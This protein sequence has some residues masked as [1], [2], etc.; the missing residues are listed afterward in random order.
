VNQLRE[1]LT[2][3]LIGL[4][5]QDASDEWQWFEP[6]VS[7]DNAKLPHA[8]ILSGRWAG[9]PRALEIGLLTLRWL[10]DKQRSASGHFRPIGCNGFY[11][12]GG[13]P[14]EFDQ[15]P[16]EAQSMVSACI[17]AYR[18]TNDAFW[19]NQAHVAFEWFLGR[20]VLGLWLYDP[21]S[22]GCRDGLHSDRVNQNQ[23][24]ESTLAFLLALTEMQLLE[25]S[26]ATFRQATEAG[27]REVEPHEQP[28][29]AR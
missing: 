1:T 21:H 8:L 29:H 26:L 17:E 22:G 6:T 14:A 10:A 9:N 18:V 7:Y 20:N 25:N 11:A 27:E 4:Y 24:A 12:R 2:D 28:A 16:L 23:G 15:Q 5:D 19:L 13:E 3:R